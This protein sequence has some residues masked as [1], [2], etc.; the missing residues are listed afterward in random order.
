[1]LRTAIC[2]LAI[3]LMWTSSLQMCK[4]AA[5]TFGRHEAFTLGALTASM[6]NAQGILSAQSAGFVACTNRVDADCR[7]ALDQAKALETR[8][9][10]LAGAQNRLWVALLNQTVN[11][12]Y[13]QNLANCSSGAAAE[14]QV[15]AGR[16]AYDQA[17]A[18]QVQDQNALLLRSASS[19]SDRVS[20]KATDAV[21]SVLSCALP[22]GHCAFGARSV[23]DS[24]SDSMQQVLQTHDYNVNRASQ[25]AQ[26]AQAQLD[27]AFA[28]VDSVQ[29]VLADLQAAG[30]TLASAPSRS[31]ALRLGLAGFPN[32][33]SA[34]DLAQAVLLP[35]SAH[36][37]SQVASAD[38]DLHDLWQHLAQGAPQYAPPSLA[39][40]KQVSSTLLDGQAQVAMGVDN[41]SA[42]AGQL[43]LTHGQAWNVDAPIDAV[44]A[45][46]DSLDRLEL[47]LVNL[48]LAWR[49][50]ETLRLWYKYWAP[51][52]LVL[53]PIDVRPAARRSRAHRAVAQVVLPFVLVTIALSLLAG[54]WSATLDIYGP[55]QQAF[56]AGCVRSADSVTWTQDSHTTLNTNLV[57]A[58]FQWAF[59]AG[60]ASSDAHLA[61]AWRLANAMCANQTGATRVTHQDSVREL[62]SVWDLAKAVGPA[63]D[64][65]EACSDMAAMMSN[66]SFALPAEELDVFQCQDLLLGCSERCI[67]PQTSAVNAT[68]KQAGCM[69]EGLAHAYAQ[70]VLLAMLMYICL[71]VARMTLIDGIVHGCFARR[72]GMLPARPVL[73]EWAVEGGAKGAQ[74]H[75]A[76][77]DAKRSWLLS[78]SACREHDRAV[79]RRGVGMIGAT[80]LIHVLWLGV[81]DSVGRGWR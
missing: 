50:V 38:Q 48:D 68:M 17:F 64:A 4:E 34:S 29:A 35:A 19:T 71:N 13:A 63:C 73:A 60:Q 69:A 23:L 46:V 61:A 14:Q 51:T 31:G 40:P 21:Q 80:A 2:V 15:A 44:R 12:C 54:A 53:A 76:C 58:G 30:I 22:G 5:Q 47:V 43:D 32:L 66:G 27:A 18:Q 49:A 56:Q 6:H 1:M 36:A 16:D 33:P 8:R 3:V 78:A 57:S 62:Q 26:L 25:Y 7:A 59:R 24:Y 20:A 81:G 79:W 9:C 28:F 67:G 45:F 65:A 75:G 39:M 42:L 70:S 55:Y 77:R 10:G 41:A 37:S 52:A 74:P 11:A 72:V